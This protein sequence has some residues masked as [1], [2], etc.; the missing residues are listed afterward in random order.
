LK[1]LLFSFIVFIFVSVSFGQYDIG[2]KFIEPIEYGISELV[3]PVQP[4]GIYM[5]SITENGQF[6]RVLILFVEFKDDQ[7]D[8]DF[9][10]WPKNHAPEDWM[11]TN[12]I[13]QTV[14]QNSTNGNITDYFTTMSLEK[15]KIIGDFYYHVTSKTRDEYITL[16]MRRGAIN[17]EILHEM[18]STGFDFTAYDN[19]S[20]N[21]PYDFTWGPDGE[22][23]MIWMIYRNISLDKPNSFEYAAKL[24]FGDSYWGI[25][26]GESSLGGGGILNINGNMTIDLNGLGLVSGINIMGVKNGLW[27]VKSTA[28]HEF[29]H[30][31]LG[32]FYEAHMQRGSWGIMSG[33]GLRGQV[34][35]SYERQ[36]L[37]WIIPKQYDYNTSDPII[38]GDYVTTGDALIIKIPG[39]SRCYRIE[40][41]QRISPL[42]DIDWTSDGKG[43]YVLYQGGDYNID[44][45][46]YS[47]DGKAIWTFDHFGVHPNGAQV[48]IFLR[49]RQDNI[50]GR[51]DTEAIPYFNPN[52]QE[53]EWS[54]IEGFVNS[55]GVDTFQPLFK[56][57]GK[58]MMRPGYV[59]VFS[60]W[61]NPSLESVAFQVISEDDKIK[62]IQKVETG[63]QID[64]PPAKPQN[65]NADSNSNYFPAIKWDANIEPDIVGG[66]YKIYRT[67]RDSTLPVNYYLIATINAPLQADSF[68]VWQDYNVKM[69][70]PGDEKLYYKVVA[71]DNT[72]KEYVFSETD[73]IYYKEIL[74]GTV[75]AQF[76]LS[77][78]YPNPFN[79]ST[80]IKYSI[81]EKSEVQI[82]VFN[83]LG[84]K[85]K[86]LVN[87]EK[88][89]GEYEV[90]FDGSTL[91][92]G[93]YLYQLQAGGYISVKKMLLLK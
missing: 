18:D 66:T 60:P 57:D 3:P 52:T 21:A 40:N 4:G 15:Y 84:E 23:D 30:H 10:D 71:V 76:S 36:K 28:I 54:V 45:Y 69:G 19:W 55:D 22:I 24:G 79:P 42:D 27:W 46:F 13:D 17:R 81:P 37:G 53:Q 58:D 50:N 67:G 2:A 62:I 35:N 72:G 16:G 32:P 14:D 77:Q 12:F 31:L 78:N 63:T 47:A 56:G 74:I 61:S 85:I 8:V 11:N 73:W 33:Y 68:V 90:E 65:L 26:S 34:V 87:E 48:P 20:K 64:L 92:S 82:K 93:V 91:P 83:V 9:S 88:P 43:I 75:P 38:L 39:T 49:G 41:H 51:F 86:T 29:G 6:V 7:W 70:R 59:E 1:Q 25:F 80:K 44:N 89:A 5:P